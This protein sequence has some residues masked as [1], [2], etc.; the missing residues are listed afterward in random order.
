M[1]EDVGKRYEAYGWHVQNLGEDMSLNRIEQELPTARAHQDQ[2]SLI[3][4]R[5]HIA[6]GAPHKQDTAGAHGSPLGE[7]EIRLTKEAS[8][9]PSQEPFFIPD[10]AWEQFRRAVARGNDAREAWRARFERY[11][12]D[13]PD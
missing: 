9:W 2:P 13:F 6:V 4:V 8:G 3:I 5:T 11:R 7:E 12:N 10:A 1:S